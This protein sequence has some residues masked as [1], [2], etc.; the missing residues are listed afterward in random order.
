MIPM[1]ENMEVMRNLVI[2]SR[3]EIT[4]LYQHWKGMMRGLNY[5]FSSARERSSK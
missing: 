3:L 2:S 4:L 1:T 5:T